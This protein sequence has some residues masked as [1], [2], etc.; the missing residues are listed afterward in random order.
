MDRPIAKVADHGRTKARCAR[1]IFTLREVS[2]FARFW[3]PFRPGRSLPVT[4][5]LPQIR[6]RE[7]TDGI[8]CGVRSG[9]QDVHAT[10]T[11]SARVR[12]Q[13]RGE[14]CRRG[15][16]AQ[17]RQ[18]RVF[19][20]R[21]ISGAVLAFIDFLVRA[22]GF[23]AFAWFYPR[24]LVRLDSI[25]DDKYRH[26]RRRALPL[27]SPGHQTSARAPVVGARSYLADDSVSGRTGQAVPR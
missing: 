7:K 25:C 19:V 3:V 4:S 11:C 9:C 16:A 15:H 17:W 20:A 6:H 18:S 27:V 13:Q 26:A 8:A 5:E 14:A 23:I 1:E 24:C 22:V 21:H 12:P 10:T 2:V